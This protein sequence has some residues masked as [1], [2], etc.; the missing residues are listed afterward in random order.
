VA[1]NIWTFF[2]THNK[3]FQNPDHNHCIYLYFGCKFVDAFYFQT[4]DNFIILGFELNTLSLFYIRMKPS[5]SET[6]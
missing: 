2:W 1:A 5:S 3:H 4:A 6:N